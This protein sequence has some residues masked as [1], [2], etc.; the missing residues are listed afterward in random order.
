VAKKMRMIK[1]PWRQFWLEHCRDASLR[2]SSRPT[3]YMPRRRRRRI[4]RGWYQ[5]D[6]PTR[7]V[8]Q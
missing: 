3:G 1:V 7:V 6:K 4:V 8:K 5:R 2:D